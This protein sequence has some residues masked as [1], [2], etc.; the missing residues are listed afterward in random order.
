[1][2]RDPVLGMLQCTHQGVLAAQVNHTQR[3]GS[4]HQFAQANPQFDDQFLA[5]VTEAVASFATTGAAAPGDH[6]AAADVLND[7]ITE[8]EV[9]EALTNLNNGKAASPHT[10]VPNELLKYGGSS[11]A[12]LLMPLFTAVWRTAALPQAWT[13][14]VIQYFFKSGDPASMGNYR[15]CVAS[16]CWMWLANCSTRF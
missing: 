11:M 2:M 4:Q 14:G 16:P 13:K 6:E 1:M 10:G 7:P 8:D 9:L 12:R 5:H 3:L 15:R